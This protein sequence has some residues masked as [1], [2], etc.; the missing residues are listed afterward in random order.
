MQSQSALPSPYSFMSSI[1]PI[2]RRVRH[3][4]HARL[5]PL[6]RLRCTAPHRINPVDM[7]QPAL[8]PIHRIQLQPR[9]RRL[10]GRP[11]RRIARCG[12]R[13]VFLGDG[14]AVLAFGC[15]VEVEDGGR[16][17]AEEVVARDEHVGGLEVVGWVGG[18]RVVDDEV[19][20]HGGEGGVVAF[21]AGGVVE[22]GDGADG[23]W[24][25]GG[26]GVG[27][28]VVLVEELVSRERR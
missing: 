22:G 1:D 27:A 25:R 13:S 12:T 19:G 16:V 15:Q 6:T 3:T 28:G 24:G 21:G 10:A 18:E 20:H 14:I 17:V 26:G 4:K 2:L 8:G 11:L 5:Q 7:L 23:G 9:D